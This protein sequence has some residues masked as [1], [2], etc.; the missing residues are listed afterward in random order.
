[1]D[2]EDCSKAWQHA[3]WGESAKHGIALALVHP[4]HRISSRDILAKLRSIRP[5][6]QM[7]EECLE[8]TLRKI[9]GNLEGKSKLVMEEVFIQEAIDKLV[10]AWGK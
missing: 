1:L 9:D 2:A 4:D 10:T 5:G 7:D 3:W 8:L 6:W